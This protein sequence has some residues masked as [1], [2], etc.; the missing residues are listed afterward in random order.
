MITFTSSYGAVNMDNPILGDADQYNLG[1]I[2]KI[3]MS[4]AIHST[5]Q[6]DVISTFLL[7]FDNVIQSKY[8][9]F[10]DWFVG[11][12]GLVITYNDYNGVDYTGIIKNEPLEVTIDGK[13]YCDLASADEF[14]KATITI[15]F[16]AQR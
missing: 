12:R 8:V 1:T 16:E 13:R 7:T 3:T 4:K 15:E 10:M 5:K 9:E 11:S 14:E 6:K 2:Y